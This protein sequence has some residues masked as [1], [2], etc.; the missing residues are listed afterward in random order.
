[1]YVAKS[2]P[3]DTADDPI[4]SSSSWNQT[5]SYTRAAQPLAANSTRRIANGAPINLG[6]IP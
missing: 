5:I 4:T 3:S 6:M 1:M 2:T